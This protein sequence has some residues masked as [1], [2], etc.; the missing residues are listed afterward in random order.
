MRGHNQQ[1]RIRERGYSRKK[2]APCR[3]RQNRVHDE[4]GYRIGC[5]KGDRVG[6][7]RGLREPPAGMSEDRPERN[8]VL[9]GRT[10]RQNVNRRLC[11][12]HR[13]STS[14]LKTARP[15]PVKFPL[16][17]DPVP[18]RC[19]GWRTPLLLPW[20]E[21]PQSVAHSWLGFRVGPGWPTDC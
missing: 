20:G 4:Y 12:L 6:A 8:L 13:T 11:V 17:C 2:I 9:S 7:G 1:R 19:A 18:L 3:I 15:A 5:E 16:E 10:D 21:M 14:A